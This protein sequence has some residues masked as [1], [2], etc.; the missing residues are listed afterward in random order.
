MIK[1]KKIIKKYWVWP[2]LMLLAVVFFVSTASFNYYTQGYSEQGDFVKWA[3]PDETANYIFAKLYGQEGKIGIEES[4]NLYTSDIMHPRSFRSDSGSLKPMSFLGIILIYGSVVKLTTYKILPFLTPAIGAI[5]LIFYYLFIRKIFTAQIAI[6]SV[7]LL[8]SFPVYIYFTARSMFHNILFTVLLIISL[9]FSTFLAKVKTDK[10]A[11]LKN[12]FSLKKKIDYKSMIMAALA[13]MFLG[14]AIITRT[15]ELL[16]LIPLFVFLWLINIRRVGLIKLLVFLS[17]LGMSILPT[18]YYNTILYSSP[19]F[20][21][22]AE[23]NTS[24]ITIKDASTDL[25]RTVV[26]VEVGFV[27]D[28]LKKIT[29]TIFHF[30]FHPRQSLKMFYLY[31]VQMFGI[32]FWP[33]ILGLIIFFINI[34]KQKKR[35]FVFL[36]ALALLSL[37]LIFYYGSWKFHDNPDPNS[38]TIGNSYTRYWLPIYLGLIP[39]A[40]L[41]INKLV[42]AFCQFLRLNPKENGQLDLFSHKSR[43]NFCKVFLSII[44]LSPFFFISTQFVLHGSDEGLIFLAQRQKD[45]RQEWQ[46]IINLTESNSTIITRYHDKLMFPERKVIVGLFDDKKMVEKYANL[47][48]YLP[49]YYYNF[50]LPQ[51]DIDYLNN[52]RLKEVGLQ[53]EE[54][55]KVTQDFT[56]YKLEKVEESRTSIE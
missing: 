26:R 30:G 50:T 19:Y 47:V 14:L 25:I 21:G 33:A 38:V 24:I 16:W 4:Y 39:F 10:T 2:V 15:S 23:M 52:R 54:I 17:F 11:W 9:Y 36:S 28:L 3:S 8:S 42:L 49:V 41:F 44:L 43:K 27:K 6:I 1:I 12:I 22:Y 5:G 55:K 7:A 53:I 31:V 34:R 20:G 40:S 37:I 51:K 32:Y 13:G 56:L 46:K 48:N 29:N 35:H 18:L 45:S